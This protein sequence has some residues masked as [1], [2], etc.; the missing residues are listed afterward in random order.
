LML[1]AML[2]ATLVACAGSVRHLHPFDGTRTI[3][4]SSPNDDAVEITYLGTAGM[5]L[6]RGGD[7]IMT[8]P[9]FSNPSMLRVALLPIAPDRDR[10]EAGL[11]GVDV[12]DVK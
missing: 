6:R 11:A 4:C 8:A 9:F 12:T 10:I 3:G 7:A 1:A 2:A 5:L